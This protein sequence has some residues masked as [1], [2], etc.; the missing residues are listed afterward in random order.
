MIH[1]LNPA[2]SHPDS[3]VHDCNDWPFTP[4]P[5]GFATTNLP[6]TD[7]RQTID[8]HPEPRSVLPIPRPGRQRRS[9]SRRPDANLSALQQSLLLAALQAQAS[10]QPSTTAARLALPS[11]ADLTYDAPVMAGPK[12]EGPFISPLDA[13]LDSFNDF[14][15]DLDYLDG[16]NSFDFEDADLGG[17]MLGALPSDDPTST[18]AEKHDKRGIPDEN[19]A[20]E[21]DAK[22]Q[23]TQGGERGA[24]KPGRKPLTSEPTT[25][26][27]AQNRAAQRAF[28]E[29][30]E[31][32][33]KDLEIK[34]DELTKAQEADKHENGMLRA[35]VARLQTELKES[36]KSLSLGGANTRSPPL[37][38]TGRRSQS[39]SKEVTRANFSFDFPEFGTL[40]GSSPSDD[41][42][43]TARHSTASP[44]T[45]T[46]RAMSTVSQ[47]S[48]R[49]GRENN[50]SNTN[51]P[52]TT[53]GLT[54]S[55]T[56]MNTFMPKV[57]YSTIDNMHGFADT[58]PQMS[59]D[60]LGSLFSPS[61]LKTGS[62]DGNDFFGTSQIPANSNT[63]GGD[64]TAGLNRAFR[65]NSGSSTSDSASPST[66]SSSRW[67]ANGGNSSCGTS[68]EPSHDSPGTKEKSVE[69]T[70]DKING[71]QDWSQLHSNTPL[72]NTNFTNFNVPSTA[73][74]DPLL[75]DNYRDA[76]DSFLNNDLAGTFFDDALHPAAYDFGSPSNL[77]GIL[78]SPQPTQAQLPNNAPAPSR[79]LMAEVERTRDG[80]D[81]DHAPGSNPEKKLINCNNIWNQLQS[82][83][84]YQD[85]KF[86]LDSLCSELR[87]KARCSE[88]GVMV[89]QQHVEAAL[90][91]LGNNEVGKQQKPQ[92]LPN[93]M[94]EQESWDN[95]LKKMSGTA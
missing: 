80:G 24:K 86:D 2:S 35:Q 74:F 31:K 57:G 47:Q 70:T 61:I 22:R 60:A 56:Q 95:V 27:K 54:A 91:K 88:R 13:E 48:S 19:E 50:A 20:E 89:P 44:L 32:H 30:K 76:N 93:L 79:N 9:D 42:L 29:R 75:F 58:I 1:H 82:N 73:T 3:R 49:P 67:N 63:N 10:D 33:L 41:R 17:K 83:P 53:P 68:P 6:M 71:L 52:L 11:P 92:H 34:V 51:S 78:Q 62:M 90:R 18:Q 8:S 40:A 21:G 72:S 16:D 94:R 39:G 15:P 59:N 55:P 77:F 5:D 45:S 69:S 46:G 4:K 84:D 12:S 64:S 26:R 66:T 65:F 25:K 81:D 36:R 37:A 43:T 23:E 14:S 85:G 38:A 28:R 7:Q 87:T